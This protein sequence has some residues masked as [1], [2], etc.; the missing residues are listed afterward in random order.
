MSH[1]QECIGYCLEYL[2]SRSLSHVYNTPLFEHYY[3]KHQGHLGNAYSIGVNA[4]DLMI[5]N[6]EPKKMEV[7]NDDRRNES[8]TGTTERA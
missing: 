1:K 3:R 2:Q 6:Y 7:S 8:E 4:A 5:N